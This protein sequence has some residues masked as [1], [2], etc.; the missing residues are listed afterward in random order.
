MSDLDPKDPN[1]PATYSIDWH[2]ELVNQAYRER[3]FT[4]GSFVQAP[5]DTGFYY[6]CTTAGRTGRNYPAQW[7]IAAGETVQDGSLVWTCRHPTGAN[8]PNISSVTWTVPSGLNQ[9]SASIEGGVI[10][11]ITVSGGTDG[12]DYEVLCRMT[13]N[14]G[15]ARERTITVKVRAQ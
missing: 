13:P 4:S 6:E 5:R 11:N 1:V 10:A 15:A 7:P 12:V 14:V 8:V 3:A 2:D 9:D